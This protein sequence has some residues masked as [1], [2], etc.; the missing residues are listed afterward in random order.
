MKII[1]KRI[2]TIANGI[3][4]DE[5]WNIEK[6][7]KK[8]KKKYWKRKTNLQDM[9]RL[10]E[11]L[12]TYIEFSWWVCVCTLVSTIFKIKDVYIFHFR[13]CPRRLKSVRTP[14]WKFHS[15][16]IK[17][18]AELSIYWVYASGS[19]GTT[20]IAVKMKIAASHTLF[21]A[22]YIHTHNKSIYY[23]KA[24]LSR[25]EKKKKEGKTIH[26]HWHCSIH[27]NIS[28]TLKIPINYW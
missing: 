25:T 5:K 14:N 15:P 12:K 13:L 3:R 28:C 20:L 8:K 21:L 24:M 16:A 18:D 22:I 7:R 19:L 23:L 17:N 10:A 9:L 27:R 4:C 2:S 26:R 11:R 6:K 1:S